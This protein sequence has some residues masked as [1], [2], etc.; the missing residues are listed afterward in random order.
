MPSLRRS[1]PARPQAGSPIPSRSPGYPP[2]R[3]WAGRPGLTNSTGRC[4]SWP[5]TPPATS[6]GRPSTWTAA[7]PAA[8]AMAGARALSGDE[9]L[10]G[11]ARAGRDVGTAAATQLRAE[12]HDTDWT[13]WI[14]SVPGTVVSLPQTPF[15][16]L[17]SHVP[18]SSFPP[19]AQLPAE[20][21]DTEERCSSRDTAFRPGMDIGLPQS[22]FFSLT[23]NAAL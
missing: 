18:T 11:V 15:F 8:E 4:Y 13:A 19:A 21:H 9:P 12:A 14:G 20:A 2:T 5:P 7:G 22:P 10:E 3:R 16:S 23:R 1:S 6:P 17:A